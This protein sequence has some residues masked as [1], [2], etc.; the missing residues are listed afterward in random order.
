[1]KDE[2]SFLNADGRRL[3]QEEE[4]MLRDF[5]DRLASTLPETKASDDSA[6]VT[7]QKRSD[8]PLVFEINTIRGR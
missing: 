3:T 8:E 2:L 7:A 4:K 1:L 5:R 6:V